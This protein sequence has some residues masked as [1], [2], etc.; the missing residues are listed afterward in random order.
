MS[1]LKKI[2]IYCNTESTL[3]S[4]WTDTTLTQCP[5]NAAHTVDPNSVFVDVESTDTI[6]YYKLASA[7]AA[8]G[9]I[10][11]VTAGGQAAVGFKYPAKYIFEEKSAAFLNCCHISDTQFI[12]V[13]TSTMSFPTANNGFAVVC[14]IVDDT[15]EYGT[16]VCFTGTSSTALTSISIVAINSTDVAIAYRGASAGNIVFGAVSGSGTSATITF[17]SVGTFNA[18]APGNQ[19]GTIYILRMSATQIVVVYRDTSNS[20]RGTWILGT[21]SGSGAGTTVTWNTKTVFQNNT[22]ANNQYALSA[23]VLDATRFIVAYDNNNVSL[24][25]VIGTIAGT[26]AGATI[27]AGVTLDNIDTAGTKS[28]RDC[29]IVTMGTDE[30]LL[31]YRRTVDNITRGRAMRITTTNSATAAASQAITAGSAIYY[32]DAAGIQSPMAVAI[33]ATRAVISYVGANSGNSGELA[34]VDIV[35]GAPALI[36]TGIL[37]APSLFYNCLCENSLGQIIVHFRDV[38]YFNTGSSILGLVG[39]TDITFYET[40]GRTIAGVAMDAGSTN[41]VIRVYTGKN[42]DFLSG[43]TPGDVYYAHSDGTLDNSNA[44]KNNTDSPVLFGTAISATQLLKQ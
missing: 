31:F 10:M 22:T 4:A 14:T 19:P 20:G 27:T 23:S 7:S 41:D 35:S 16:P 36:H 40:T 24:A 13:Y 5:N 18:T 34:I 1:G 38:N 17:S 43:L 9:D 21:L 3:V 32:T 25:A 29:A 12:V 33:S 15:I 8:I 30:C 39:S 42:V 11:S 26:G 44:Q 28:G 37:Y 2:S 6:S